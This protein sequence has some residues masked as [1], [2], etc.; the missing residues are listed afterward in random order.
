MHSN[1]FTHSPLN[2]CAIM[3]LRTLKV[4]LKVQICPTNGRYQGRV[5]ELWSNRQLTCIVQRSECRSHLIQKNKYFDFM[6]LPEIN[7][8]VCSCWMFSGR[9]RTKQMA[10][11]MQLRK[12]IL[13]IRYLLYSCC[14]RKLVLESL[15]G[16]EV[17]SSPFN[18]CNLRQW[19]EPPTRVIYG[20][21]GSS[22]GLWDT[23][24]ICHTI[25]TYCLKLRSLCFARYV[26]DEHL[27]N[28]SEIFEQSN[29]NE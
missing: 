19:T 3:L 4:T 25:T 15:S 28:T 18:H 22:V 16:Q 21:T 7:L 6:K 11:L 14:C 24:K 8:D 23:R 10:V 9:A 12:R 20:S 1:P 26:I 2:G 5:T 17:A 29:M 13:S 27:Y